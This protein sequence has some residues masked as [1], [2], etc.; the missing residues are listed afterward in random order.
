MLGDVTLFH[1]NGGFIFHEKANINFS[2]Q[3]FRK[4]GWGEWG[5]LENHVTVF[6][7]SSCNY[8]N[9]TVKLSISN[10]ATTPSGRPVTTGIAFGGNKN[11][12]L[13]CDAVLSG[14]GTGFSGTESE[15]ISCTMTIASSSSW[16]PNS[17]WTT[18]INTGYSGSNNI[19]SDCKAV[20]ENILSGWASA[21][22]SVTGTSIGFSGQNCRYTNCIA[23]ASVG[24]GVS[25]S[26]SGSGTVKNAATGFSGNNNLYSNCT[27][28]GIGTATFSIW[29]GSGTATGTGIGFDG[30]N[31]TYSG[32]IGSGSGSGI[33]TAGSG[34]GESWGISFT[35]HN[36]ILLG[37]RAKYH[38]PTGINAFGYRSTATGWGVYHSIQNCIFEFARQSSNPDSIAANMRAVD[39]GISFNIV[40]TIV[41]NIVNDRIGNGNTVFVVP[42]NHQN[43]IVMSGNHLITLPTVILP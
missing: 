16:N 1:N 19:Y 42:Q 21:M 11:T 26:G 12:Y 38:T 24:G 6:G 10:A 30:N 40:A 7:G 35:G 9:C 31:N 36:N 22:A 17:V 23:S 29:S 39:I 25:G 20:I 13:S 3:D 27:G 34:T 18:G 5:W 33:V 2:Y 14:S 4:N 41:G 43:R 32:C 37:C 28:V 15:Y 8:I